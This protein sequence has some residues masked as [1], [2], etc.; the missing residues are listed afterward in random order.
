MRAVAG[1]K[2]VRRAKWPEVAEDK[3]RTAVA[4]ADSVVGG[5]AGLGI[6]AVCR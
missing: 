3:A 6:S 4:E 5:P 1:E 2:N